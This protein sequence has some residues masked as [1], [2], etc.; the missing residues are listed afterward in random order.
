MN[1]GVEVIGV[2]LNAGCPVY[3]ALMNGTSPP[4]AHLE[5][6]CKR[7]RLTSPPRVETTWIEALNAGCRLCRTC[8]ARLVAQV[9]EAAR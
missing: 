7:H 4:L 9:R 1:R 6:D 2:D 5:R 8:Q 3:V